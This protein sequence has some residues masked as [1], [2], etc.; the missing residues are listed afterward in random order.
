[1]AR[2]M[3]RRSPA[4]MRQIAICMVNELVTRMAVTTIGRREL[5]G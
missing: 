5:E 1:M 4:R 2:F 3:P